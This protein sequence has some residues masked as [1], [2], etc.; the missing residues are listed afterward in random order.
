MTGSVEHWHRVEQVL[1]GAL[2]LSAGERAAYLERT[3]AGEPALRAQVD[4]WLRWCDEVRRFL[5][6]PAHRFARP[7]IRCQPPPR[8]PP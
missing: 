7:L 2:E 5:D 3:C 8:P 6:V 4:G 1:D